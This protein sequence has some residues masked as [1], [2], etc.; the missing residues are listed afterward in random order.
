MLRFCTCTPEVC[1]IDWAGQTPCR[2]LQHWC[3]RL[4][5]FLFQDNNNLK[6]HFSFCCQLWESEALCFCRWRVHCAVMILPPIM[7]TDRIEAS[8]ATGPCHMM[9]K[10]IDEVTVELACCCRA[11]LPVAGRG[12]L[13]HWGGDGGGHVSWPCLHQPRAWAS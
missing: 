10:V 6:N 9:G 12:F 7:V 8:G 4:V 11:V 1:P 13:W 2:L 5:L 3:S